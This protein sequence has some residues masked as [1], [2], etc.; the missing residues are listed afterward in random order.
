[1]EICVLE[2]NFKVLFTSAAA[3]LN[4]SFKQNNNR[5]MQRAELLLKFAAEAELVGS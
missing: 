3:I 1:M 2:N 5:K 4:K